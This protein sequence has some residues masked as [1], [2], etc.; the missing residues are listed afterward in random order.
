MTGKGAVGVNLDIDR[1]KGTMAGA[2]DGFDFAR[3][4]AAVLF[5]SF[6]E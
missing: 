6:C 3:S 5:L 2:Q 4:V 1:A